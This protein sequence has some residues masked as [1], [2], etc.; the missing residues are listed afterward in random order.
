MH[1]VVIHRFTSMCTGAA[2]GNSHTIPDWSDRA[3]QCQ[4]IDRRPNG[5]TIRGERLAAR[6]NA[7]FTQWENE[8]RPLPTVPSNTGKVGRVSCRSERGLRIFS[9]G[10]GRRTKLI[11][12]EKKRKLE[13]ERNWVLKM[14]GWKKSYFVLKGVPPAAKEKKRKIID[15]F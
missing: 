12:F 10:S 8:D 13:P 4:T 6:Q 2:F 7:W 3:E 15:Q 9:L 11:I 1:C 5:E 14:Y